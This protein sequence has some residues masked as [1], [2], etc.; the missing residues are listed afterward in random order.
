MSY[1]PDD[2]RVTFRQ[3]L[4]GWSLCLALAGLALAAMGHHRAMSSANSGG[5]AFSAEVSRPTRTAD[6]R[7]LASCGAEGATT[8]SAALRRVPLPTSPC[9]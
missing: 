2:Q 9:S 4:A 8:A 1:N 7:L 6:Y 5:A 3:I